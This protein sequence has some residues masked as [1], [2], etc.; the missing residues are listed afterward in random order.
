MEL[1]AQDR[2]KVQRFVDFRTLHALAVVAVV[3]AGIEVGS[4]SANFDKI[5][6]RHHFLLSAQ[7]TIGLSTRLPLI[8]CQNSKRMR[9]NSVY[10]GMARMQATER[11]S[12]FHCWRF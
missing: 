1:A 2:V 3:H 10:S 6:G 7:N 12:A 8:L 9:A 11:P 5:K 4:E